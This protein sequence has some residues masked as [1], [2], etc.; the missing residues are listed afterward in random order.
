V[1]NSRGR[2]AVVGLGLPYSPTSDHPHSP[3]SARCT[4]RNEVSREGWD[5]PIAGTPGRTRTSAGLWM[6]RDKHPHRAAGWDPWQG[7]SRD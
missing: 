1:C 3:G 7:I 6:A 2:D 5:R 4:I